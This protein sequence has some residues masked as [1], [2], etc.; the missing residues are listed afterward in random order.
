MHL[1]PLFFG[2]LLGI[3]TVLVLIALRLPVGVALFLTGSAGIAIIT[4][5]HVLLAQLQDVG[6]GLFSNYTSLSVIPFF[7][8]MGQLA[9]HGGLSHELFVGTR[10]LLGQRPISIGHTTIAA[11]GMFGA[12]CGSSL[13]TS[14]TIGRIALPLL[15]GCGYPDGKAAGIVAAGG[16]LGILIPPSIGLIVYGIV[17]E[18]NIVALFAAA[19]IPGV[20]AMV[21]FMITISIT[22]RNL[23]TQNQ[24]AGSRDGDGEDEGK[25]SAWR[26]V[27]PVG[28]FA[29]VLVG[30]FVGWY[31]PN[32]AAAIGVFLVLSYGLIRRQLT[33]ASLCTALLET[34]TLSAMIGMILLGA[35]LFSAFL[36][37]TG[38]AD[39]VVQ[40][41]QEG[42]FSPYT[43]LLVMM[44]GLIIAGCFIESLSMIVLVVPICWP[45]IADFAV[46]GYFGNI[47]IDGARLWFGILALVVIELGLITP[48]IGL[49]V[50]LV[51]KLAGNIPVGACFRGVMPFVASELIRVGFLIAFPALTL[52]I[53]TLLN[54]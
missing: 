21:F 18:A 6:Y 23:G 1:D 14:A 51:Q 33:W 31:S 41:V 7:V 42:E 17:V 26:L 9:V 4:N 12:I 40:W 46:A 32:N 30:I 45:I 3:G 39:H 28:I 13:A 2:G 25:A 29:V 44:L 27:I 50:F 15:R 38:L 20:L 10:A 19:L 53:P 22:A 5:T 49:N 54:Q 47:G 11:S 34:A 8:L 35:T 43:V 24:H 16:C 37:H 48:P 52:Y 36:A